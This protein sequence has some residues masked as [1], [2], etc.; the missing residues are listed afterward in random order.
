MLLTAFHC[1]ESGLEFVCWN[2]AFGHAHSFL[3]TLCLAPKHRKIKSGAKAHSLLYVQ[4]GLLPFL[5]GSLGKP[6]GYELPGNLASVGSR[7]DTLR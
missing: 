2:V 6:Q 1:F 3:M 5:H 7:K 4:F